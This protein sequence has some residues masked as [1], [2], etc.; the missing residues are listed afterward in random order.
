MRKDSLVLAALTAFLLIPGCA[1]TSKQDSAGLTPDQASA[2]LGGSATAPGNEQRTVWQRMTSPVFAKNGATRSKRTDFKNDPISLA[3]KAREPDAELYT[4]LAMLAEKSGHVDQAMAQL[5]KALAVEPNNP[6]TLV[7]YGHVLERRGQLAEATVKYEQAI[8]AHPNSTQALN[9]L[10]LCQAR[11]GNL[12]ASASTLAKAVRLQPERPLY[13]NNLATV[14]VE[15]GRTDDALAELAAVHP[16]PIAHY[17]LGTLLYRRGDA[18]AAAGHYAQAGA[19][20]PSFVAARSMATKLGAPT[21]RSI[22][23]SFNAAG[24]DPQ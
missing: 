17:N 3:T 19:L 22:P 1:G 5:D 24:G 20:D 12:P 21:Q 13:R 7:T 23:A 15:Q 8:K 11:M 10:G 2:I 16:L 6:K 14:L 4:S 18:Q 9:D